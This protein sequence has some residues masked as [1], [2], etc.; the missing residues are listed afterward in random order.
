MKSLTKTSTCSETIAAI[1]S[2]FHGQ[3]EIVFYL[4]FCNLTLAVHCTYY[5]K[6]KTIINYFFF[7]MNQYYTYVY[8]M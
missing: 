8:I 3:V 1:L 2:S 4:P 6:S 7:N 5:T